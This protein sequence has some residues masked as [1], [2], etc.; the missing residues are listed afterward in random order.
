M[1]GVLV[2]LL[3]TAPLMAHVMSMSTGDAVLSGNHLEFVLR[4]PMYEIAHVRDPEHAL[5]E[6]IRFS[7]A[8]QPARALNQTCREDRAQASYLCAA[9]YQFPQPVEHLDV[10]CTLYAVT[11]PNHVH[12]LRAVRGEKHD[13]GIFDYSFTHASLRFEPPTPLEIAGTQAGEG[14]L[15]AVS[16][17]VQILFLASLALAARSRRELFAIIAAFLAGQIASALV[18]PH[19]SWQPPPRFVEAAMA[20]AV[21]Y[22]A[23]EILF[24]KGAG[25]R[26]VI[27][28][29]LGSFHGLYFALF[30]QTTGYQPAYV[31]GGAAV[32][33]VLVIVILAALFAWIRRRL[34][35]LRF[36]PV[37]ASFMLAI[38]MVWFAIRLRS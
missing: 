24:L 23:V 33:E 30:L 22:L 19:T 35:V 27:A 7:S 8:G 32:T 3:L 36:V 13:Q 10:D 21:A 2:F 15:R 25:M 18:V 16:G 34:P 17:L 14:M 37:A 6:H 9:Y 20:L 11:V 28:G 26:W 29:V 4:I 1:N 5:F 12:L 38:G 31:L